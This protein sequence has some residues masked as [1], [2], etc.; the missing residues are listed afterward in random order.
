MR[1]EFCRG[2]AEEFART[3]KYVWLGCRDCHHSWRDGV[4]AAVAGSPSMASAHGTT[5]N[6]KRGLST[7]NGFLLAAIVVAVAFG[8]R[9]AAKPLLGN[10]SPFLVFTPALM[11]AAFYGGPVAG[12]LATLLSTL[13]G[14]HFFLRTLGEPGVETW[15]RIALF[16]LVGASIT[17]LSAVVRTT[18]RRLAESLWREQHAR[19]QAEAANQTKDDFL[20]LVSHELQTPVTVVIGWTS[21]IRTCQLSGEALHR[22]LDAMEGGARMLS[23]LVEDV[24][25]TS[26]IVS[27][28]LRLDP[29]VVSLSSVVRSAVEQLRPTIDKHQLQLEVDLADEELPVRA[30]PVR[31]QQVFTNLLSNA[32]KFTPDGGRVAVKM[33]RASMD[34]ASHAAVTVSDTGVGITPEFLPRVFQRFEQDPHTLS[35]SRRGLGLGLSISRHFVERHGGT[36]QVASEG[37]GKGASFTVALPLETA[38]ASG[39]ETIRP[40]IAQ[41][42]LRPSPSSKGSRKHNLAGGMSPTISATS[43]AAWRSARAARIGTSRPERP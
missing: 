6:S 41:Q 32:V 18:R 1:C 25:D 22:A 8:I 7:V 12:A 4:D 9:L 42:A 38:E 37:P 17:S 34:A 21:T 28:T 20:A 15:D 35:Y 40:R 43:G 2:H 3:Q 39:P 31:L 14:S 10:A 11:V 19:A 5:L 26:R 23:K 36:I 30:D 27:G 13:L 29:R 16:L 33:T 24:M